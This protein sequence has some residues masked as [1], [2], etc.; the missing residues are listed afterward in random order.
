M[1]D[2]DRRADMRVCQCRERFGFALHA[3]QERVLVC[4]RAE[5]HED[6]AIARAIDR[7]ETD[8]GTRYGFDYFVPAEGCSWCEP[9]DEL[10][11]GQGRCPVDHRGD[12]QLRAS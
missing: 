12:W 6:D 7:L 11:P 3:G 4:R 10:L 1:A 5:R 8:V 2:F 9:H